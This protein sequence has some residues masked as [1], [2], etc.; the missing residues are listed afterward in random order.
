MSKE[1]LLFVQDVRL[2]ERAYLVVLARHFQTEAEAKAV[3]ARIAD[4]LGKAEEA[5]TVMATTYDIF[6]VPDG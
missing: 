6:P 4:S 3:A 2:Y 1:K 5:F